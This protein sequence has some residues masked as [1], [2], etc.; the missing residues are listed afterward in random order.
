MM[1]FLYPL[2]KKD[3]SAFKTS[4]E[5]ESLIKSETI[6]QFGFNPSNLSWHGGIH[7]TD[8]NTPWL[9]DTSPLQAIADGVVVAC[10]VNDKYQQSQFEGHTLD[11]SNDFCLLQHTVA[12]PNQDGN[13]FTFYVLYM[14]LAPLCEPHRVVSTH[15][16]YLLTKSRNV[17]FEAGMG[18]KGIELGVDAIVEVTEDD[19]VKQDGYVFKPFNVI[20]S[21]K[22]SELEGKKVWLATHKEGQPT[23]ITRG[24]F[25][26]SEYFIAWDQPPLP[27]L[28][29]KKD[30]QVLFD[31][32]SQ[33]VSKSLRVN[34]RI[35]AITQEPIRKGDDVLQAYEIIDNSHYIQV[36]G[37]NTEDVVWI[38]T[39]RY[40]NDIDLFSHFSQPYQVSNWLMTDVT[41]KTKVD[42]LSGRGDPKSNAQGK[43]VAG[44]LAYALPLGTQLKYNRVKDC[45]FQLIGSQMRL[46]ARCQLDPTTPVKSSS[47]QLAR[48]V[49][50]CVEDEY[51]EVVD[52]Q[53]LELNQTH[54]FGAHSTLAVKAGDAIGYLGR[55]DVA[56]MDDEA[57]VSKR[58]Q[59][60]FE[61]LSNEQPPQFFI[62]M[63]LGKKDEKNENP[64][65][66]VEDYS[67]CDGF[68]DLDEPS[69]FFQ[70][71][72]KSYQTEQHL[73][74][75]TDIVENLTS[76]D[77]CKHVIAKHES[78]WAT[79][80][81]NKS[82]LAKL[83][84]KYSDA[85]FTQLIEHEKERIDNLIWIPEVSKLGIGDDVWNWWPASQ[86]MGKSKKCLCNNPITVE[87]LIAILGQR[88]VNNGLFERGEG[89][90]RNIPANK[91]LL[92]LNFY[93]D[94]FEINTCLSKI[95]FLSQCLIESDMFRTAS[96]YKNRDGSYPAA[97][98][99][100]L[101]GAKYHGRGIIQITHNVHYK[102]YWNFIKQ[103]RNEQNIDLLS[104]DINHVV[105]SAAWFWRYFCPWGN[106]NKFANKN[107]F[108]KV[109]VSVNGGYNHVY[110]RNLALYKLSKLVQCENVDF[111]KLNFKSFKFENSSILNSRYYKT[112]I[113]AINKAK[114]DLRKMRNV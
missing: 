10:R 18:T 46:M 78:E 30:V 16:R 27:C 95:H 34:S 36:P 54:C 17:R 56:T 80:S 3:G 20:R 4:S 103:P 9:Q 62:D 94:K 63:F 100:Y 96:E 15:P 111:S 38:A 37:L 92:A 69:E 108:L 99:N 79:P 14:H 41:V 93:L 77:S 21:Y 113:N 5:F 32:N 7:F 85:K 35:K 51:V 40:D 12:D 72:V 112:H 8:K 104:S 26:S 76:W 98:N 52:S 22:A 19:A 101:G 87:H 28:S 74:K 88:R 75:G 102:K 29:L 55:Y 25:A 43:L 84:E 109:T 68:L 89:K 90:L 39:S 45:S 60:H 48:E 58:H 61:L 73:I 65:L 106:I 71:L 82:F 31:P 105:Q 50:V 11:Y 24:L 110:E 47:G 57:P 44:G 59:V 23:P 70:K 97:W 64:Y 6:G 1:T 2:N 67:K 49:W 33:E 107:D 83:V 86:E 81:S 114:N 13:S 66:I 53:S 42:G 91:F